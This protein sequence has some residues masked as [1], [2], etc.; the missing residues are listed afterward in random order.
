MRA[1]VA[2][3]TIIW[4]MILVLSSNFSSTKGHSQSTRAGLFV[5][6][7]DGVVIDNSA[8]LGWQKNDDGKRRTWSA[9]KAYCRALSL[10]G[11]SDWRL[12]TLQE[13]LSLWKRAG[14]SNEVKREFF[15]TMKSSD[16]VYDG[17][18]APYWSSTAGG[19]GIP[20]VSSDTAA[21]VSFKD[22][23]A[24]VGTKEFFSFYI[25]CVRS[26]K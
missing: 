12:P 23:S 14:S 13:L 2:L 16:E 4:L 25:R 19:G 1:S 10:G 20:N 5:D 18:F 17:V 3:R 9:S 22:G 7:G 21:F 8:G 11:H 15:P 6:G 24:H 26:G